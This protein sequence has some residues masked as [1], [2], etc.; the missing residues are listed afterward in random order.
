VDDAVYLREHWHGAPVLRYDRERRV[1]D[2]LEPRAL[3]RDAAY[4]KGTWQRV[5]GHVVGIFASPSGPMF[6]LD[7]IVLVP[8]RYARVGIDAGG[9]HDRFHL[10]VTSVEVLSLWYVPDQGDEWF[11]AEDFDLLRWLVARAADVRFLVSFTTADLLPTWWLWSR[12][13]FE[14]PPPPRTVE[15]SGPHFSSGLRELWHRYLSESLDDR[16]GDHFIEYILELGERAISLR[17]RDDVQLDTLVTLR[18]WEAAHAGLS[19]QLGEAHAALLD[20]HA[21]PVGAILRMVEQ[22]ETPAELSR[23]LTRAA[24]G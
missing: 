20:T 2:E 14:W 5:Q 21:D 4:S 22:A 3:P 13:R 24:G 1:I 6:L 18:E 10:S 19:Y 12:D 16:G 15:T 7:T 11:E 23:A 17:G 8:L 9:H